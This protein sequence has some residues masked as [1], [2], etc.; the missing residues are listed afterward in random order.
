[1]SKI[2]S[3]RPPLARLM[4]IHNRI[5]AG[6]R[7]NATILKE[8]F[9]VERWTMIRDAEFMGSSWSLPIEFDEQRNSY[10]YTAPVQRLPAAQVTEGE[11][12]TV[13][14][15]RQAIETYRGTDF[16]PQLASSFDK[17]TAAM[18]DTVS[19]TPSAEAAA[20]SLKSRGAGKNDVKVFQI[21][22]RGVVQERELTFDYRKPGEAQPELRRVQPYH[23]ANRD[24][25][26]YLV[27]YDRDRRAVRT[28]AAPRVTRP[29]LLRIKFKRPADF[30]SKKYFA[31]ALHALGG[32]GC[33][34]V[35]LRFSGA[36][37][38]RVAEREWH[39]T[40][41]L[42]WLEDRRLELTMT[43]GALAEVERWLMGWGPEVEV[44][45]PLELRQRVHKAALAMAATHADA[46]G[47][48]VER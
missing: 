16:Y 30:C 31:T 38:D 17:L 36:T 2:P 29:S 44:V 28:F 37:A 41:Q 25:L 22:S 33:F 4:F 9:G 3:S 43:L 40:Q 5:L 46:P 39:E 42:R 8:A 12:L 19:F 34:R 18:R 15:I 47:G 21:L 32:T 13:Q 1:M 7:V 48:N 14:L 35:V 10:V 6:K 23:L 24:N 27:G 26:W 20:L 11:M 45:S